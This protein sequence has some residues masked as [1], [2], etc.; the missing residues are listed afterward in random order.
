[1]NIALVIAGGSGT[2]TGQDVP[3][4]FLT[5]NDKPIIIYTLENLDKL[6]CIDE[7]I[8]VV[9]SGWECYLRAYAKQFNIVK[10]KNIVLGGNSRHGSINNGVNYIRE[11]YRQL[12]KIII[13]DANRPLIPEN[14]FLNAI[15]AISDENDIVCTC[16]PCYDSMYYSKDGKIITKNMQREFLFNG[17]SPECG[18]VFSICELYDQANSKGIEGATSELCVLFGKKVKMIKG[19]SINFKITTKDDLILFKALLDSKI[20]YLN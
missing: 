20:N 2:R 9:A 16:S 12:D 18:T 8:V 1:M 19:S 3:K 10:L 15:S 5:I 11:N 14:I 7:I 13:V 4:Q 6:N 17:Q